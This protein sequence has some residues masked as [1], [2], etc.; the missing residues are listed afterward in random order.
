[1][2]PR[3]NFCHLSSTDVVSMTGAQSLVWGLMTAGLRRF[4]SH[5][6]GILFWGWLWEWKALDD[7]GTHLP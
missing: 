5:E 6:G 4:A 1:M 2:S 3:L 7:P